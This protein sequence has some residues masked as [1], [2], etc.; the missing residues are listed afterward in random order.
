MPRKTQKPVKYDTIVRGTNDY[1]PVTFQRQV[2]V[3]PETGDP[4]SE[5]ILVP[6]DL[7]GR[8]A[9]M[10]VKKKEYDGTYDSK[11]WQKELMDQST[12]TSDID[13]TLEDSPLSPWDQDY[14]WRITIDCDDP[15]EGAAGPTDKKYHWENNYQGMYGMSPKEG[16][17]VFRITKKMTMIK[18]GVYYFDVRIME[19]MQKQIGMI[20]ESRD[21][22]PVLGTFEI[23]G[24]PT[25]R[26]A[27][28][29]WIDITNTEEGMNQ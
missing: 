6:F 3:D 29:D 19:K 7:T 18:P 17:V 10:T 20:R 2:W 9:I 12:P 11:D 8:L 14:L 25:N 1:I 13:R 22:S 23:Q 16:R 28:Y 4:L 27:V 15:T 26:S 21:W 5:P 24:T